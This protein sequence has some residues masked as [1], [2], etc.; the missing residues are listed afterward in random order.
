MCGDYCVGNLKDGVLVDW[1][2]WTQH[3]R[4]VCDGLYFRFPSSLLYT[5]TPFTHPEHRGT[6]LA[7][8]GDHTLWTS[9]W[10]NITDL[11]LFRVGLVYRLHELRITPCATKSPARSSTCRLDSDHT[12]VWTLLLFQF[13][14]LSKIRGRL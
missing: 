1:D 12:L 3:S 8:I 6:R 4:R 10:P 11:S 2:F 13:V 7:A 5:F 14:R 9:F